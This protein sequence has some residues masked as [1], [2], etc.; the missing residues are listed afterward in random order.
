MANTVVI[1]NASAGPLAFLQFST[2][3]SGATKTKTMF[4]VDLDPF[5]GA[6]DRVAALGGYVTIDGVARAGSQLVTA[7]ATLAAATRA[8]YADTTSGFYTLT[9]MAL[10]AVPMYTIVS[11]NFAVDGGDLTLDGD[12]AETIDGGATLVL[13][14]VG[15]KRLQKTSPTTWVSI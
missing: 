11:I 5:V 4:T 9:M 14:D 15:I 8:V 12:G 7:V 1:S 6:L 13:T 3:A 2:V 10:A